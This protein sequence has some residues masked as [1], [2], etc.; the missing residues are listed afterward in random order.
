ML[1][2]S[3]AA[4]STTNAVNPTPRSPALLNPSIL[5][6]VTPEC[7]RKYTENTI[8]ATRG[9]TAAVAP[10]WKPPPGVRWPWNAIDAATARIMPMV[11]LVTVFTISDIPS[12]PLR[13][14][15]GRVTPL[16]RATDAII[17]RK[18]TAVSNNVSRPR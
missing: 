11:S 1:P 9:A 5:F 2:L 10:P 3:S 8:R 16:M 15:S 6:F 18:N 7:S 17:A 12:E 4:M 14:F 13:G